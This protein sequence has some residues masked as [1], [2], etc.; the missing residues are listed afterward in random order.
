MRLLLIAPKSHFTDQMISALR[1]LGIEV[2]WVND[3][4]WKKNR[5]LWRMSRRWRWLRNINTRLLNAHILRKTPDAVLVNKG[6]DIMPETLEVFRQKKIPTANWFPDNA[7]VP[8][9]QE[10]LQRMIP[11]YDYFFLFHEDVPGTI[12]LPVAVDP[13]Y[14]AFAD[15]DRRYAHRIVFVGA[16]FPEREAV[17]S[18]IRDLNPVV[19][20]SSAWATSSFR[21]SYLG[22]LT[23]KQFSAVYV[24]SD[25]SININTDPP[26]PGVNLKT[27]EIPLCGGFQL[28]DY[29]PG[30]ENLFE[31]G[32]E[33]VVFKNTKE[34]RAMV[35]YYLSHSDERHA[36]AE[37]GRARVLKDHTMVLRMKTICDKLFSTSASIATGIPAMR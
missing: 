4:A 24:L 2:D 12:F 33:I 23:P 1:A 8:E 17:L 5:F 7:H 37:A 35:E 20:G 3:R 36:I 22:A 21:S 6:I 10:W 34:L 29:R 14:F 9:Y 19:Y 27:F 30:L 28:S 11:R 31:I 25:I 26:V 32:K 16:Y 15:P 18:A 13:S